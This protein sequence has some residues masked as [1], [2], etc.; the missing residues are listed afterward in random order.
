MRE[1]LNN[2]VLVSGSGRNV[3]KTTL[4]CNIIRNLSHDYT[5]FGA[6]I[7]PHF[8]K[9]SELQKLIGEGEGFKIYQELNA[10][11][12]KDSSRMLE[13]GAR[14]VY[15]IQCGDDRIKI[16]LESIS[17]LLPKDSPI[18]C[19]SGSFAKTY[20][21]GLHL[22]VVGEQPDETKKSYQ[23]NL[24]NADFTI[25]RSDFSVKENYFDL[26]YNGTKWKINRK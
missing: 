20:K 18:V 22:L 8:H 10:D 1:I 17:N 23:Q 11:S 25:T 4:A 7:S 26:K 14:E 15:F 9:T 12:G 13:S 19:E 6:K 3:G 16:A 5:V 2:F 21:P 24:A